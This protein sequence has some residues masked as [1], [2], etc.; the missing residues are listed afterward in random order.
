MHPQFHTPYMRI[1]GPGGAVGMQ[2]HLRD[3]SMNHTK[4]SFYPNIEP[5]SEHIWKPAIGAVIRVG[6]ILNS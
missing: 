1:F 5:K 6:T 4:N 3:R 2:S